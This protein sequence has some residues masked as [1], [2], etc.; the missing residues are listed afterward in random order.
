MRTAL[1]RTIMVVGG[2]IIIE[3]LGIYRPFDW[4]GIGIG[5][6]LIIIGSTIKV[7]IEVK[8]DDIT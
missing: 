3:S 7:L 1:S 4:Q 2:A 6:L 8:E 5:I